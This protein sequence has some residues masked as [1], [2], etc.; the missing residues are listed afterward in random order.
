MIQEKTE[1]LKQRQ[2]FV[3]EVGITLHSSLLISSMNEENFIFEILVDFDLQTNSHSL[4]I[5]RNDYKQ[6]LQVILNYMMKLI[7]E[8]FFH[9]DISRLS[10]QMELEQKLRWQMHS[11]RYIHSLL[12][13][14]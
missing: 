2:M 4:V 13:N 14:R 5:S 8:P 11:M 12:K 10:V 3:K 1:H 6:L 7:M 9:G